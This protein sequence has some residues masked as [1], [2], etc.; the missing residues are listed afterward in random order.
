MAL[1]VRVLV[2]RLTRWLLATWAVQ[3]VGLDVLVLRSRLRVLLHCVLLLSAR[4][5]RSGEIIY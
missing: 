3:P 2:V 5:N 4:Q 1:D